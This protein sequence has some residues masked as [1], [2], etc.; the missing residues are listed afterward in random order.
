MK[1]DWNLWGPALS[2]V[3]SLLVVLLF[4]LRGF[5]QMDSRI[6]DIHKRFDDIN[7]R[8]DDMREFIRSE[9]KRLEERIDK[10][11]GVLIKKP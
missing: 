8:F 7:K 3:G 4:N 1:P 5:A 9:V 10:R 11:D 6:G 2:V